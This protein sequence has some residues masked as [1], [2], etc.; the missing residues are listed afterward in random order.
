MALRAELDAG[1][2][3]ALAGADALGVAVGPPATAGVGGDRAAAHRCL[4]R[5]A[6]RRAALALPAAPEG[7]E[8]VCDYAALGL[9]LRRHPLALLRPR[10]ARMRLLS[11]QQLLDLPDGRTVR[12]CGI[13]TMRQRPG[14]PRARCS[15]RSRTRPGCVNVIVWNHVAEAWRE[16]LLKAHLLAVQGTWQRDKESRGEVRHLIA[17][18]FKDLTPLLGRL[19]EEQSESAFSS[20]VRLRRAKKK[21]PEGGLASKQYGA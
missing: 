15:S 3:A 21:P 18:G 4:L 9:T 13:V 11:C 19:G 2:M 12:A 6:H 10:L 8:I 7:E 1:D 16:P 14:P 17:S 5:G 20:G